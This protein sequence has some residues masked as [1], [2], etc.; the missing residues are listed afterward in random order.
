MQKIRNAQGEVL[1]VAYH[2]GERD[3]VLVIFGHGLTGQKETPVLFWLGRALAHDGWPCL[4]FSFSGNGKSEGAFVDSNLSKEVADLMAVMDQ[5]GSGKKIVYIGHSM[6]AAVGALT[7]GRDERIK[8]MVSLAG[9]VYTRAFC[10]REF[11]EHLPEKDGMWGDEAFLLSQKFIDDLTCVG[12]TM[13]A[14]RGLRTPWLLI[15]GSEDDVIPPVES[16]DLLN[17]LRGPRRFV[18]MKG[19][20]HLFENHYNE[21]IE[22]TRSWLVA[23]LG[24]K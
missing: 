18:E 2:D 9:M 23:H 7:V 11:A 5:V 14:V 24:E 10:E 15:H 13:D 21:V 1:D 17:V 19:A 8:L 22:E 6:G 12:S 16:E 4:R 20:G 3:D